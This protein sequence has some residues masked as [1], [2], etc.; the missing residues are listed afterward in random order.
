MKDYDHGMSIL[1][2]DN[3]IFKDGA[4]YESIIMQS[5]PEKKLI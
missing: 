1:R 5:D 4:D 3:F 2:M